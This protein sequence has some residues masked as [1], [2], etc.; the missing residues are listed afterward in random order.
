MRLLHIILCALALFRITGADLAVM[1]THAWVTMIYERADQGIETAIASTFSGDAPCAK[2]LSLKEE[3]KERRE[4]PELSAH[5]IDKLKLPLPP[6]LS[7]IPLRYSHLSFSSF[8]PPPSL[9]SL[10][11]QEVLSP[12]PQIG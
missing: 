1:Q 9:T 3:K 11:F 12:P 8:L 2:C 7:I 4:S 6:C 10:Y 5:S